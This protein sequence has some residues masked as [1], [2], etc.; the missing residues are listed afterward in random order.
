M[1]AS[2]SQ[3]QLRLCKPGPHARVPST[4][5]AGG[6]IRRGAKAGGRLPR[7]PRHRHPRRRRRACTGRRS[8]R[9]ARP[10]PRA[11]RLLPFNAR[12]RGSTSSGAVRQAE[13]VDVD[14]KTAAVPD[15]GSWTP[16]PRLQHCLSSASRGG[17]KH[18]ATLLPALGDVVDFRNEPGTGAVDSLM[19]DCLAPALLHANADVNSADADAASTAQRQPGAGPRTA[20]DDR[21]R[22]R[23]AP[24]GSCRDAYVCTDSL[25]GVALSYAVTAE[26]RVCSCAHVHRPCAVQHP[27]LTSGHEDPAGSEADQRTGFGLRNVVGRAALLLRRRP[28]RRATRPSPSQRR[29]RMHTLDIELPRSCGRPA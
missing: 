14:V 11:G 4:L 9:P 18:S 3:T 5:P 28:N 6:A 10:Q 17:P 25:E 21:R 13:V 29:A 2:L 24:A 26:A 23:R 12:R 16:A 19:D 7:R 22:A 27:K 8:P 1:S 20:A 15:A